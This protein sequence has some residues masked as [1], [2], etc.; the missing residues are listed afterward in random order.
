MRQNILWA[1]LLSACAAEGA[2][3]KREGR[4]GALALATER[5]VVFKDGHALLVK[6]AEAVADARGATYTDEVPESAVL[7]TFWAWTE[8]G[9]ALRAMRAQWLEQE[10]EREERGLCTDPASI[11]EI[12]P[13][14]RVTVELENAS[15]TGT[16]LPIPAKASS[17]SPPPSARSASFDYTA[18]PG[19]AALGQV[20]ALAVP[21]RGTVVLAGKDIRRVSGADLSLDCKRKVRAV[22]KSKRLILD[23]GPEAAGKSISVRIVYFTP[24]IRWIPTYRLEGKKGEKGALALQA[25]LVNE[26][27]DI[28]GA[29]FDLVVGVPNFRFR[30]VASPLS[31]EGMVRNALAQ[32]AP[33]LMGRMNNLSNAMFTQRAGEWRGGGEQEEVSTPPNIPDFGGAS[34]SP[35]FFIHPLAAM[36]LPKGSR[37][38]VPLWSAE[39][40]T[41]DLYTLDVQVRRDSRNSDTVQYGSSMSSMGSA[42]PLRLARAEVWHQLELKNETK[43]P[44]TTGPVLVMRGHIPQAQ[45]LLTYTMRGGNTL[46]PL[47][48]ATDVRALHEEV[49]VER[50]QDALQS[51]GGRYALIRKKGTLT[52]SNPRAERTPL[53]IRLSTG[54]KVEQVSGGGRTKVDDFRFEDWGDSDLAA[55]NNHS[56]VEWTLT[57]EPGE[58]RTLT[59]EVGFWR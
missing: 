21:E 50:K 6:Q 57:L 47:T 19:V 39:I 25:E 41:R 2:E 56:E 27:E 49:E 42:S 33:S 13:G 28:R 43:Y 35:D 18:L 31:L 10:V 16:V 23:F 5:V 38:V 53:R 46:V 58:R 4:S 59:Y 55:V 52:L 14:K 45:E 12:N 3:P 29:P 26:L 36:D 37:A 11:L 1:L 44:W 22:E 17:A 30:E 9:P 8:R 40:P 7:G 15:L 51:K 54:G 24:G 48:V 32:A 34:E 20:I